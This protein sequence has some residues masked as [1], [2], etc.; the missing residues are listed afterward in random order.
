MTRVYYVDTAIPSD[1]KKR[2]KEKTHVVFDGRKM[3]RVRRLTELEDAAGIYI[4]ALFPEL[5]DEI[6][7]L[8]RRGVRVY[9]LKDVRKLKKLRMENDLKKTDE[10]D[11]MLLARIPIEKFRPLTIEELEFKMRTRP[12]IREYEKIV[13]WRKTLKKLISQGFNYNFEEAVRLM[14]L[15]R[16]KISR[17]IVRQVVNLPLYGEVYRRA[18][19]IL[20]VKKSAELA[21]LVIELPLHLPLV[22]LRGLLGLIPGKNEGRYHHR[23]RN[24][25]ASFATMLYA[26]AKSRKG[27]SDEVME[28]VNYLPK[29]K[30]ILKLEL[31]ILK[32]LR[33]AYLTTVK[34]P[35]GE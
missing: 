7:E 35:A 14:D 19:E 27:F 5:Y 3:F 12:L 21:I 4:D 25:T 31:I 9:L 2:R 17:K 26:H 6:L 30:A 22:R 10:T 16:Q 24:H 32:A 34:P 20:G 28:V 11:A 23:L 15:E 8:L 18:C 33:T 13:R 29:K 1:R